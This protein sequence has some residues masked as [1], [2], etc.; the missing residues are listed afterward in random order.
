M[1]QT[2]SSEVI[3]AT[4]FDS[5]CDLLIT[6]VVLLAVLLAPH[7]DFPVDGVTGCLVA[8]MILFGGVKI[9]RDT[10]DPLL[11][12]RPD[13]KLVEELEKRLLSCKGISGIH[14]IIIHN[15]GPNQHFATAHAE[16]SSEGN[17]QAMHDILEAAEVEIARTMPVQLIL[18]CDPFVTDNPEVKLWHDRALKAVKDL[19]RKF[20]LYDFHLDDVPGTLKMHFNLLIPRNHALSEEEITRLLTTSL[21]SYDDKLTVQID[22]T[23]SFI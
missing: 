9:I 11:G 7:T 16:V 23:K 1:S 8:L 4:A 2:H 17:L 21:Q 20:K 6:A 19:D 18:H 12:I 10:M 3:R 15:Y 14:D 22:Y 13:K 5:L